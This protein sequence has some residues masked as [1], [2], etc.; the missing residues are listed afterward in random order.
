MREWISLPAQ[1]EAPSQT[2]VMKETKKNTEELGQCSYSTE[3]GDS[4]SLLSKNLA[5]PAN[6]QRFRMR[7]PD[8]EQGCLFHHHTDPFCSTSA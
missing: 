6:V 7:R 2:P 1:T 4:S 8:V 3:D 5:R